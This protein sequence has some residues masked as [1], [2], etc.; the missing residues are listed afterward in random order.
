M[1]KSLKSSVIWFCAAIATCIA[2]ILLLRVSVS[3][4]FYITNDIPI[5]FSFEDIVYAL[6][7]GGIYGMI[8][9]IGSIVLNRFNNH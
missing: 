9:G 8:L 5:E 2:F 6:K 3:I 4:Y 7:R 1:K